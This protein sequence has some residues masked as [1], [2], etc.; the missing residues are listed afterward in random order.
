MPRNHTLP[1]LTTPL[2]QSAA[3][4]S[5]ATNPKKRLVM[6]TSERMLLTLLVLIPAADSF[7]PSLLFRQHHA[8]PTRLYSTLM[9]PSEMKLGQIQKELKE[10][11]VSYTDCFDRESLTRRLVEARNGE[12][13]SCEPERKQESPTTTTSEEP[14]N[15]FSSFD[16][17]ATLKELRSLRVKEL[18][19]EMAERNIRWGTMVEKEDLVQAL[20]KAREAASNFSSSGALMPGQVADINADIL[21]IELSNPASTPLL[22]DVY[23]VW[24]G[25]CQMMSPQLKMAAEEL[26][27]SVRVAKIDSDKHPE[28]ASQLRV[29]GLPTVIVFDGS[30]NEVERVEG[31]LMSDG[32]VQLARKHL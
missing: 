22:L 18:R 6:F 9:D 23:A 8:V 3:S 15:V 12:I 16:R 21:K 1:F 4:V 11:G 14:T 27:D 25:P 5:A 13:P 17:E 20:L 30:G 10:M 31:A 7:S 2:D 32:L 29:G 19:A 26:G 28:W 24:C